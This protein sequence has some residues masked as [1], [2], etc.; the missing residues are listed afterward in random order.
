[1][2]EIY[3]P[4][5]LSDL[6]GNEKAV[7]KLVATIKQKGKVFVYGP[8]GVGKT[9]TV[10]LVAKTNNLRLIETNASDSR[11]RGE[12]KDIIQQSQ[13]RPMFASGILILL[14]EVDGV[15]SWVDVKTLLRKSR[16]AVVLTANDKYNV[17]QDV[18]KL[19]TEVRF[20]RPNLEDVVKR[21]KN[22]MGSSGVNYRGVTRDFRHSLNAAYYGGGKY[23]ELDTFEII[24]SFF[25]EGKVDDLDRV[26]PTL[27]PWLVENAPD[28]YP[29]ARLF[30]FYQTLAIADK[31]K[32]LR[33]MSG[34]KTELKGKVK[35]PNYYRRRGVLRRGKDNGETT[36]E[37]T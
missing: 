11:R 17:P 6:V 16:H 36:T 10:E 2:A 15:E 8:P 31:A 22:T 14:D 1:M 13:M 5:N 3:K 4:R 20:Y 21:I 25:S 7:A 26:K 9:I 30:E 35:Y 24:E 37:D 18:L 34:F 28:N 23:K 29:S 33:I 19:C 12:L 27:Y 32:D